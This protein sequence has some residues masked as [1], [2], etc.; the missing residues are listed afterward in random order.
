MEYYSSY[1]TK[2]VEQLGSLPGIGR[3]TAQ[4]LAFHIMNMPVDRAQALADAI[5]E[6]RNHIR[7]CSQC[8]TLTDEE[9]AEIARLDGTKRY[10]VADE[11]T[12]AKYAELHLPFEG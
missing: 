11:E 7:Y 8:F 4:R 3:K 1:I 5:T 2:L 12:V 9:M 10:Y 6:A